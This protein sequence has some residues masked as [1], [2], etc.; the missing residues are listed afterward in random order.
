MPVTSEHRQLFDIELE[1]VAGS[2]FQPT[3]FP[4]IG[5][6][7][8]DRPV[9][10]EGK[11]TWVDALILE[12]AQSMANHLEAT[13]WDRGSQ[14][15]VPA[16]QGLPYVRVVAADDGRYLTSSRTEAHRL[17]SA[18]IKDSTLEGRSM[19]DV[20]R[21]RLGLSN[22]TPLA[23]RD[24]AAQ[25][26]ALDPL[27]LIHGVFFADNRWPGQP[28]VARAVTGFVEALD[29]R[30]AVSGGVKRDDVRH[31]LGDSGGTA[32][33]YGFVPF[34]RTEYTAGRIVASF[35]I[36]R[37]QIRAYGLRPAATELL[38]A[39][40]Q[41]EL[42]ALLDGG[43]RL[44]TACDLMP[45]GDSIQDQDGRPL[46]GSEE[47]TADVERLIEG[48]GDLLGD[49]QPI[50]VRWAGGAKREKRTRGETQQ[51]PAEG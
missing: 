41:W 20:M 13:G 39:I 46:P 36:D 4:D 26:F 19:V 32:E 5:A 22:D 11:V 7:V 17:A 14:A 45:A 35:S 50:E 30:P 27:C 28:K 9:R 43:L 25:V 47:L 38:E 3:G 6:A 51:E 40:A 31:Q 15:A 21:E 12:S 8:F 33:G 10:E 44:R 23:P 34:H 16:L 2:R 42:R 49:G 48:C 1:P 29:V 18:F 37:A 24:I